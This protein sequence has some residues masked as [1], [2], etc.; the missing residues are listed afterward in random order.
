MGVGVRDCLFLA[1]VLGGTGILGAG[2][3]RL[4]GAP[5]AQPSKQGRCYVGSLRRSSR[6]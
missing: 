2:L 4:S 3:V 5:P 6:R 1:V